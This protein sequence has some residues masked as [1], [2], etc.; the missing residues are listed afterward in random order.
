MCLSGAGREW[1]GQDEAGGGRLLQ[2][3]QN[4]GKGGTFQTG[5]FG[6]LC[7]ATGVVG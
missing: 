6:E 4:N 2:V 3:L 7:K 1:Q 5:K